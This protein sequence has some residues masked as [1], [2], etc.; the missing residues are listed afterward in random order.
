VQLQWKISGFVK[1]HDDTPNT[2]I[3]QGIK[4]RECRG[5]ELQGCLLAKV[6][7][8]GADERIAFLSDLKNPVVITIAIASD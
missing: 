5:L 4:D 8:R 3:L 7:R 6:C 1:I 2:G